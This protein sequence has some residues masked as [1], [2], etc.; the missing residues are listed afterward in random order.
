MWPCTFDARLAEW[1]RLRQQC[2][3]LPLESALEAIN[4]WWF[5]VPW[6]AYHLHWDDRPTWPDP[7]QLL[8]DNIYCSLARGLGIMYTITLI[9][10]SDL[11]TA[12]LT[13]HGADNLVVISQKKYILN[14]D[15]DQIVNIN[16]TPIKTRHSVGQHQLKQII[17]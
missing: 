11:Q 6:T 13:E 3:D 17:K 4:T 14:W 5:Q 10:R 16:I 8:E 1:T 15:K 7:W 2:A 9:D 12:Q